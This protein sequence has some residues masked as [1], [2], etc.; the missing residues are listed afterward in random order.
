[1]VPAGLVKEGWAASQGKPRVAAA[2]REPRSRNPRRLGCGGAHL[3]LQV[4][5][6]L[7][8][9]PEAKG[10]CELGSQRPA[11]AQT[12]ASILS[13]STLTQALQPP[14]LPGTPSGSKAEFGPG[15][16]IQSVLERDVT[17]M[18]AIPGRRSRLFPP[19]A[20][21]LCFRKPRAPPLTPAPTPRPCSASLLIFEGLNS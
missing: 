21:G 17:E 18:T 6:C 5:P 16:D 3:Q 12:Q 13:L 20:S 7:V 15:L 11:W 2:G 8:R 10:R 19:R 4:P 14:G 1:M 9:A